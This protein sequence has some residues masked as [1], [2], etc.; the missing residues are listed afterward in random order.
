MYSFN[1]CFISLRWPNISKLVNYKFKQPIKLHIILLLICTHQKENIDDDQDKPDDISALAQV[2][3]H[4]AD[5]D[6]SV[7]C[8]SSGAGTRR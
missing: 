7:A 2:A 6:S 3:P 8:T 1:N 5:W 4:V